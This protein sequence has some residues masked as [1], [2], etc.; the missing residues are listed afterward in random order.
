MTV[1]IRRINCRP[2]IGIELLAQLCRNWKV[3]FLHLKQDDSYSK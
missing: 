2:D 3:M 1:K